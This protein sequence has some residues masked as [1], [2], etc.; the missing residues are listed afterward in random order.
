MTA[1]KKED[2]SAGALKDFNDI[3]EAE[4]EKGDW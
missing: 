4:G 3:A 1:G 2:D